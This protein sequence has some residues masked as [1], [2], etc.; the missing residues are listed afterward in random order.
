VRVLLFAGAIVGIEHLT[1][2]MTLSCCS[3]HDIFI[4][5]RQP[6][7]RIVRPVEGP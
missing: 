4:D 3:T 6:R 7:A 1:S 2:G 5:Q